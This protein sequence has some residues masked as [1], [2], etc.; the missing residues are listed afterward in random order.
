MSERGRSRQTRLVLLVLVGLAILLPLFLACFP[1]KPSVPPSLVLP[2]GSSVRILGV[3]YGTN[4][5]LGPPLARMAARLPPLLQD[6]VV[7]LGG[8]RAVAL[9]NTTMSPAGMILW[10]DHTTNRPGGAPDSGYFE[11][12]LADASGFISG[13]QASIYGGWQNPEQLR[14]PVLP[15]RDRTN[16][17]NVFFHSATGGV[18]YCGSLPFANPVFAAFPQWAPEALPVT[19][20][21]GDVEATLEKLTTGHDNATVQRGLAGGGS[22]IEFGT[23][24]EGGRN[25]T[26][27]FLR[28]RSLTDTNQVWGVVN[29]EVS[30]ATG[31]QVHNTSLGWGSPGEGYFTFEPGLWTNEAAWKIKCEIKRLQGFAP[32][33]VIT[34]R[35][36]P[37]GGVGQTNRV[38]WSQAFSGGSVTLTELV[39]RSP[40]T[41]SSWSSD[42]CSRVTFVVN[43]AATGLHVDLISARTD[44]GTNLECGSWS[45]SG[46][47]REY[48]FRAL[49]L[50]ARTADFTVAFQQSRWVEFTVKPEVGPARL[51]KR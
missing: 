38:G 19:K 20:Q 37:L 22:A 7:T 23:N 29:E 27:C 51:L 30:D 32:E 45:A 15:R 16:T 34:F 39:R 12:L 44:T 24:R 1:P 3:T 5:I 40:N 11:A 13:G 4:H 47:T 10:L 18:A 48:F 6:L 35:D 36:V 43:G 25:K 26:V 9:G 28:L 31:N 50:E 14:F 8:R 46:N 42:S 21:V 41:N 33:E 17:L 49:P 2:D